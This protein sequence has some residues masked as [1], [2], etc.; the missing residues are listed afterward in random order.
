MSRVDWETNA[1]LSSVIGSSINEHESNTNS[2]SDRCNYPHPVACCLFILSLFFSL[3]F[4]RCS[5]TSW[6]ADCNNCAF[7]KSFG[8]RE[9]L[10]GDLVADVKE[11][12][13]NNTLLPWQLFMQSHCGFP[14]YMA[15]HFLPVTPFQHLNILFDDL[16]LS[17]SVSLPHS[18]GVLQKDS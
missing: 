10:L 15:T 14:L 18:V 17:I 7:V 6:S 1:L 2:G 11:N 3:W 5:P 4:V 8:T 9:Q 12:S 16:Y 13:Y